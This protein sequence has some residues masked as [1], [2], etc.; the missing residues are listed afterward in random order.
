M[1]KA[2]EARARETDA[3]TLREA[4]LTFDEIAKRLNYRDRGAAH[5]AYQRALQRAEPQSSD[6]ARALEVARLDRLHRA[7]WPA[8]LKGDTAAADRVLRV[9][10]R[11]SRLLGLDTLPAT[12]GASNAESGI[13]PVDDL[14]ARR[15]QRLAEA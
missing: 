1:N 11:R 13:D 4:G 15:R 3:F 9:A 6:D 7:L 14:A 10:E 8:A 2:A 5:K 12:K